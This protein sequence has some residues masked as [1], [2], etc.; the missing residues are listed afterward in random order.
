[1]ARFEQNKDLRRPLVREH[2]DLTL[3]QLGIKV[4]AGQPETAQIGLDGFIF[5]VIK[6]SPSLRGN[7]S[8]RAL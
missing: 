2:L 1:M 5:G 7:L 4:T 8:S 6:G 3:A